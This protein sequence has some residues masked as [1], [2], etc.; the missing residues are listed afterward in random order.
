MYSRVRCDTRRTIAE[1]EGEPGRAPPHLECEVV[2]G[3]HL[4]CACRRPLLVAEEEEKTV[5]TTGG[6]KHVDIVFVVEERECMQFAKQ[7]I[8]SNIA[9]KIVGKLGALKSSMRYGVIGFNG[10]EVHNEPHFHTGGYAINFDIK[11]LRSAVDSLQFESVSGS[12]GNHDPLAAIDFTSVQYPFRPTAA[13]TIVL[14]TCSQCGNQVDYYDV[15]QRLLEHNMQLH[16][17]TTEEIIA[18]AHNVEPIG[19]SARQLFTTNEGPSSTLREQLQSPHD[20]CTVLAQEMNGTVWTVSAEGSA[21]FALPAQHIANAIKEQAKL[22]DC[23]ICQCDAFQLAPR[24]NCQPCAVLEPA[25]MN[26]ASFFN[27]PL[28]ALRTMGK[29]VS[30]SMNTDQAAWMI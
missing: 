4:A 18:D 26:S 1:I 19:F 30:E 5:Q 12:W 11:G 21:E 16:V 10:E 25:S 9:Q 15:Q 28:I 17:Y 7:Q 14:L 20:S 23:M 27:N 8:V 2:V 22:N 6:S 3:G 24:T 29:K 13:K